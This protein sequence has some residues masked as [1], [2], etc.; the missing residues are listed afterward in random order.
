MRNIMLVAGMLLAVGACGKNKVDKLLSEEDG[1]KDKMCACKDKACTE[2]VQK[3]YK[4]WQKNINMSEDDMK[5]MSKDQ[6]DK[7]EAT[8]KAMR[9]CRHKYD[10]PDMPPAPPMPPAPTP[11]P[12]GSADG[13]AAGSAA[14]AGSGS[15]G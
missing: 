2:G 10:A 12:A 13:S 11:A 9:D 14:P 3:D 15:A 7:G 8:E 5:K 1:F 4:D 6:M